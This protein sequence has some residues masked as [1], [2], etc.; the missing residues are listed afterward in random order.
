MQGVPGNGKF[1]TTDQLVITLTAIIYTCSAGHAAANFP[2]YDEYGDPFNYP[3]YLS[4]FP[5]KDKVCTLYND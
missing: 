5:P 4:G 2:Q 3:Y 1:N